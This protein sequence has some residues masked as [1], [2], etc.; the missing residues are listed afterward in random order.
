[1]SLGGNIKKIREERDCKNSKKDIEF[2]TDCGQHIYGDN[3]LFAG[4]TG[5]ESADVVY[6]YLLLCSYS[7]VYT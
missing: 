1:M 2:Y 3:S 7:G 5:D 6:N 4:S